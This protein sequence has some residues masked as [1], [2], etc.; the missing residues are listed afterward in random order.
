MQQHLGFNSKEP[1]P[2]YHFSQQQILKQD[3]TFRD[4]AS[5]T[6][7]A[8]EYNYASDYMALKSA[9]SESLR[10]EW[11][12]VGRCD[13]A[14]IG[15]VPLQVVQAGGVARNDTSVVDGNDLGSSLEICA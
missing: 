3:I 1:L 14:D 15:T 5:S 6:K 4:T 9:S 13:I 8:I 10:I 11:L 12:L 2:N 7:G